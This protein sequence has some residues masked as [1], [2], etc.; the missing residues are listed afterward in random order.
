MKII[1]QEK[2]KHMKYEKFWAYGQLQ[3]LDHS[4]GDYSHKERWSRTR[5]KNYFDYDKTKE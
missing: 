2:I 4:F 3:V 1:L 5:W